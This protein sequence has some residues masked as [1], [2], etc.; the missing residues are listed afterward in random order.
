[1]QGL[2][3]LKVGVYEVTCKEIYVLLKFTEIFMGIHV[4]VIIWIF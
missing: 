4:T 2:F 3:D 1:M